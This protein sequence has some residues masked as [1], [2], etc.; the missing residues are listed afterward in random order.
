MAASSQYHGK[1]RKIIIIFLTLQIIIY[2]P[3]L[4]YGLGGGYF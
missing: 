1:K 4:G 3:T 2:F